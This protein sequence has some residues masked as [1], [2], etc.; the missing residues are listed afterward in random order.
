VLLT[1]WVSSSTTPQPTIVDAEGHTE[2][3]P[4]TDLLGPPLPP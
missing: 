2:R 3:L 1:V 4:S